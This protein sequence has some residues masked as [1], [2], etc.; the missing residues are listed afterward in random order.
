M[1]K[2]KE[3][4]E[5]HDAISFDIVSMTKDIKRAAISLKLYRDYVTGEL[6]DDADNTVF[7]I[8]NAAK[9]EDVVTFIMALERLSNTID[10]INS[11][12]CISISMRGDIMHYIDRLE[13]N[14]Y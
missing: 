5:Q 3:Q 10:D 4:A 14:A 9:Y 12:D 8:I 2:N 6:E 1:T 13:S 7:N 11:H